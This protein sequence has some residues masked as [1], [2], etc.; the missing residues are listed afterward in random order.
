[1]GRDIAPKSAHEGAKG[2]PT[3]KLKNYLLHYAKG[4]YYLV[5]LNLKK[6][7]HDQRY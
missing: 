5:N 2:S 1:M 4:K 6:K 7:G 3:P